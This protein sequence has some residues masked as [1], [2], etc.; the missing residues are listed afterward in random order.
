MD[1]R[2]APAGP[3]TKILHSRLVGGWASSSVGFT[4]N[5]RFKSL[6]LPG[7]EKETLAAVSESQEAGV[8]LGGGGGGGSFLLINTLIGSGSGGD[9]LPGERR[10]GAPAPGCLHR[11]P[12]ALAGP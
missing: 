9:S 11:G 10:F 4:R 3:V 7:A 5:S 8:Y 1:S 2:Q 12:S 6:C